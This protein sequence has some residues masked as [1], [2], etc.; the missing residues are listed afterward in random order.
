MAFK[1]VCVHS[2]HDRALNKMFEKGDVVFVQAHVERL[3]EERHKH[4]VKVAM[5]KDEESEHITPAA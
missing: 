1:L 4:F 5:T 3:K 2:F